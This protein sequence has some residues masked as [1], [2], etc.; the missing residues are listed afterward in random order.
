MAA[1]Q[2]TLTLGSLDRRRCCA[3]RPHG[4]AGGFPRLPHHQIT[5]SS[6]HF[7]RPGG[8]RDAVCDRRR[9]AKLVGVS[10][11]DTFPPEVKTLPSVGA[12]LDPNVERILS[13]KPDLVV[14]YGSQVDLKQQL[15]R[16]RH[17]RVRLPSRRSRRRHDDDPRARRAHR[18]RGEGARAR[19]PDR[20]GLRRASARGSKD[21]RGR[22]RC[23][24]SAAS[25]W[26]CAASMRAAASDS[27]TTCSTSPG[28]TNVFADV[29]VQAVQASTEQILAKRP[30]VILE[31]RAAN[32]AFPSGDRAVRAERVE[33]ARRGARGPEQSRPLPLRRPHRHSRTAR[34][35]RD[36]RDGEGAPP[37]GVP[38]WNDACIV[39]EQRQ[40]QRVGAAR[41]PA[42]T[43][44]M[45]PAC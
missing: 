38:K 10:S 26:R 1:H 18:R 34:R 41:A 2:K 30:D 17:R 11:Y 40:G 44:A 13:L 27:S 45:S 21:G 8:D 3:R 14:V 19:R 42:A 16:A 28:G 6:D 24:S 22:A 25:G 33:G 37:G 12:L 35:R 29:K 4:R 7:P 39:V 15:A 5:R 9:A 36:R 32:S 43:A 23:S 20:A 31:V